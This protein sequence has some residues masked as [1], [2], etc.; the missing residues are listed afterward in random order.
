MTKFLTEKQRNVFNFLVQFFARN[1]QLPPCHCI[2][3]EFNFAS[4]NAAFEHLL[5]IEKR[6]LIER[7]ELNKWR[8]TKGID[9]CRYMS[10]VS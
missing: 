7:N 3:R 9:I 5:A 8:F 1:H 10:G 4:Q 6:G 2:A